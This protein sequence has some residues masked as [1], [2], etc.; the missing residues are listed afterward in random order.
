MVE[1]VAEVGRAWD[2]VDA[3]YR[4]WGSPN[5]VAL[6]RISAT[7]AERMDLPEGSMG[8]KVDAACRF[9]RSGAGFAAIGALRD[10]MEILRE[11]R[12]TI[13]KGR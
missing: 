12:G 3:V 4:D 1:E 13:V 6:G 11:A 9:A 5:Q 8:P 7:D 10:A 2:G